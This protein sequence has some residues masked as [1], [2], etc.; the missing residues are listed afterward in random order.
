MRIC[1]SYLLGLQTVLSTH[2]ASQ[3]VVWNCSPLPKKLTEKYAL[4]RKLC[5]SNPLELEYF[6]FQLFSSY[7]LVSQSICSIQPKSYEYMADK[8]ILS[9][10]CQILIPTIK[11]LNKYCLK[12]V[13]FIMLSSKH[14]KFGNENDSHLSNSCFIRIAKRKTINIILY[15]L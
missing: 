12:Q 1:L 2:M 8:M 11:C 3:P 13:H 4:L 7:L 15:L 10:I 6:K 14:T 5:I 9:K